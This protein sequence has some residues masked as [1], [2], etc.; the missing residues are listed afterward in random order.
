[1]NEN[2]ETDT[3]KHEANTSDAGRMLFRLSPLAAV[4][5]VFILA[6]CQNDRFTI[7]G[8]AGASIGV[9]VSGVRNVGTKSGQAP[10]RRIDSLVI[11]DFDGETLFVEVFESD[12]TDLPFLTEDTTKGSVVDN[13]SINTEGTKFVVDAWLG[14]ENRY[15]GGAMNGRVYEATDATDY[16]FIKSGAAVRGSSA[17]SLKDSGGNEFIWRNAVPTTFWSYY[18]ETVSGDATRSITL[19]GAT[20]TDAE[21][22]KLSF[23]YSIGTDADATDLKDILFAYNIQTVTYEDA[24]NADHGR[25]RSGSESIDVHFYHALP[26]IRFDVSGLVRKGKVIKAITL[27][28]LVS[29][30]SCELEG[31]A[32][33][34]DFSGWT[35]GTEKATVRQEFSASDFTEASVDGSEDSNTLQA[36]SNGKIFFPLP[37][38]VKDSGI[39]VTIEYS[40]TGDDITLT[41]SFVLDHNEAWQSGKYYTYRLSVTGVDL[42]V[43]DEVTGN[44]KSDLVIKNIGAEPAYI[45]AMIA[46]NWVNKDGDIL[47]EWNLED[48][49]VGTIAGLNTTA[50]AKGTDGFYYHKAPVAAGAEASQLFESYTVTSRPSILE[51]SDYLEFIITA[52]SVLANDAKASAIAAWGATAASYLNN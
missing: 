44:K 33:A 10:E 7:T 23:S 26:A 27:E 20:A 38:P 37:Q 32:G 30:G 22:K 21:Q 8:G 43:D 24:N 47:L 9:A 5:A 2:H 50:W 29:S 36:F 48:T 17:W 18:P 11:D 52:Q 25:L 6:A 40:H 31:T 49:G 3:M 19:P 45:R 14:S 39:K 13:T 51:D 28:G 42:Y 15:D 16:H 4:T 34:L 1:M 41:K 35:L 12:Y 46:G